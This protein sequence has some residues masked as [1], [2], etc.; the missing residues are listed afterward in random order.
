MTRIDVRRVALA[1]GL[2]CCAA[3]KTVKAPESKISPEA[4]AKTFTFTIT[5]D[6]G[7]PATAVPD[8]ANCRQYV[9]EAK[10]PDCVYVSKSKNDKVKFKPANPSVDPKFTIAFPSEC[11][12]NTV[13][14]P[15]QPD[16]GRHWDLQIANGAPLYKQCKFTVTSGTCKPLDPTVII[17]P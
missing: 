5:F 2:L 8:D 1:A 9:P 6:N 3:C 11:V 13:P 10:D 15:S 12:L 7:C 4:V 17:G 16:D 14:D